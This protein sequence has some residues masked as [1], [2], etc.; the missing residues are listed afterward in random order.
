MKHF[1]FL[2]SIVAVLAAFIG[3]SSKAKAASENASGTEKTDT[4]TVVVQRIE[5]DTFT[6]TSTY[7]GRISPIDEAKLVCYGGGRVE[8]LHAQEGHWVKAGESLAS[9]DSSK[10]QIVLETATLQEKIAL[11]NYHQT[12]KHLKEGNASKLAV[13]QAYLA[14]LGAKS[15]RIDAEK[16]YRGALAVTPISGLVTYRS[17]QLY[18][19]LSPGFPTFSISKT[20]TMKVSINIIETDAILV[21]PGSK[22]VITTPLEPDKIWHGTIK[23]IAREATAQDRTFRAEIHIA[24]PDGLLKTGITAKVVLTLKHNTDA[25]CIPTEIIR[26]DGIQNSVMLVTAEG[27]AQQRI[28]SVGP[29]SD[30]QTVVTGGLDADDRVITEGFQLVKNGMPVHIIEK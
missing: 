20:S 25:L 11:Q 27:K 7:Y 19:E 16:I 23:S 18:Q 21:S 1:A 15:T 8:A 5:P 26:T 10:A 6:E 28:I 4:V 29:Q 22:A 9:I 14:Y 17:I 3:C 30:T 24:N 12:E 13:D 2:I